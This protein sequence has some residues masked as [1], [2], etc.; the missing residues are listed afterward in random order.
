MVL[1]PFQINPIHNP[2]KVLSYKENIDIKYTNRD[3]VINEYIAGA[4]KL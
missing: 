2:N 4:T 1:I 3:L